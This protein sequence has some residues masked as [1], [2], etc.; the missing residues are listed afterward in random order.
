MQHKAYGKRFCLAVSSPSADSGV[1]QFNFGTEILFT[2]ENQGPFTQWRTLSHVQNPIVVVSSIYDSLCEWVYSRDNQAPTMCTNSLKKHKRCCSQKLSGK[3]PHK[4][5]R[6]NNLLKW[7]KQLRQHFDD[8][9]SSQHICSQIKN[10]TKSS[11]VM[12][13]RLQSLLLVF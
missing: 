13:S 10:Q 12:N 8:F 9:S 5:L 4:F 3:K 7:T 1:T 6:T 2:V 11:I